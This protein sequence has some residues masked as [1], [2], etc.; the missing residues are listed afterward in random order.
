MNPC[1]IVQRFPAID[2]SASAASYADSTSSIAASPTA[3]VA[4]RQPRRFSSL[5]TS[6]YGAAFMVLTP[7]NVPPSPHGSTYGWRIQPPSKPPSTPSFIPPMRSHSSPS[8]GLIFAAAIAARI[9]AIDQLAVQ[10]ACGVTRDAPAGLLRRRLRDAPLLERRGIEDV[11]VATAH[12]DH[13]VAGRH[14]IEIAAIRETVF[15]ELRL[16][17]IA[18]GDDDVARPRGHH[19][20]GDRREHVGNASRVREVHAGTAAGVVQMIVG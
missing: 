18:V 17:P 6:V 11:F 20:R 5:T 2:C 9:C 15:L 13:G 8:S 10:L 1:S 7:K 14:G 16:V 12:D 19:A 3:C 4:M